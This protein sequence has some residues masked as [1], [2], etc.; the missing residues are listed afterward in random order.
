MAEI[1]AS[2]TQHRPFRDF[3]TGLGVPRSPNLRLF[4]VYNGYRLIVSTVLLSM[5]ISPA[6]RDMVGRLDQSLYAIGST[7]LLLSSVFLYGALGRIIRASE[8]GIFGMM[9]ADVVATTL[10]ANASGG[11]VSGFS[12]LY[13]IT[14]AAA[15]IL[16]RTRILATLVAA[17]TVLALLADTVYLIGRGELSIGM[18][19]PAGLL[20][21]LLFTVSLLMQTVARRLESAEA[22]V[23]AVE[24]KVAALQALNHQIIAHMQT[25]I[26]LADGDN[27][28]RPIN[29]AAERLL[30]LDTNR[31]QPLVD[32][33]PILAEQ[34]DEWRAHGG[35][36]PEPFGRDPD[37]PNLIASFASYRTGG[38]DET[39]IFL[40][41]YT[42]VTQY[43]QSLK[44]NS[45]GKLTA[46]IAHEIRNPLSAISHAGQLLHESPSLDSSDRGLCEIVVNN[47]RRV[48]EIIE[49]VMQLSRRQPPNSELLSI[50][51]WVRDFLAQYCEGRTDSSPISLIGGELAA[52]VSVDPAHLTRVLSNLLDNALRHSA[53]DTGEAGARVVLAAEPQSGEVH[54]DIIDFGA[55]VP[56]P[57]Q[58]RLFEPFFT[59]SEK[60]SGLGLYLCKEL[61]EING[62]GLIYRRTDAGESRFRVSLKTQLVDAE[63]ARA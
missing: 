3:G 50:G 41:D 35:G 44:L 32:V 33:S 20:G 16:L 13:I 53:L 60:G 42:P 21:S 34:L 4:Q 59:T 47:S 61:C 6:T 24:T 56:L 49:N 57:N 40:D 45:L 54:I 52:R 10:I 26:L 62:A 9:L 8:T 38:R 31:L 63:R 18:T 36:R 27:N 29:V 51:P 37:A 28:I 17:L 7:L 12:V 22:Q 55:G 25:G 43:A 19:L 48:N 30:Q 11:L 1:R 23:D 5:L 2:S 15:A 39:L 46:S 58:A 14:V